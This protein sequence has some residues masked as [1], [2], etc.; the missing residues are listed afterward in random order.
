[1]IGENDAFRLTSGAVLSTPMQLGPT[2]RMP[3]APD[4]ARRAAAGSA[5]PASPTSA[6]PAVITTSDFTP[7]ARALVDDVEHTPRRHGDDREIDAGGTSRDG[8]I[9][10]QAIELGRRA[11]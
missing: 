8:C 6:K 7:A 9:A 2:I 4:R 1:M 11:D 5:R 3:V 10:G